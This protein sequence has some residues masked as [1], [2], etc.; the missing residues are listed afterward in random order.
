MTGGTLSLRAGQ[1][2]NVVFGEVSSFLP[3]QLD[4]QENV[5][6]KTLFNYHVL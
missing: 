5:V 3:L 6:E 4:D 1:G 2:C